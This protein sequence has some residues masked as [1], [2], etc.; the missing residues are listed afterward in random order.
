MKQDGAHGEKILEQLRN[1]VGA[2][3]KTTAEYESANPESKLPLDEKTK[4]YY[5]QTM[6]E[7]QTT[8]RVVVEHVGP[9]S[10]E[11][12]AYI[13]ESL[14]GLV[15]VE[16]YIN[17]MQG[18]TNPF[19]MRQNGPDTARLPGARAPFYV[20]L[21]NTIPVSGS[22][23][24]VDAGGKGQLLVSVCAFRPDPFICL[25]QH[26]CF[27]ATTS[28]KD[29]AGRVVDH[30]RDYPENGIA[31]LISDRDAMFDFVL[32]DIRHKYVIPTDC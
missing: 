15:R 20:I 28:L 17:P 11:F 22:P 9:R 8:V 32:A 5:E 16:P 25:L 3:R 14:L 19:L 26:V 12:A 30:V 2:L 13:S 6:K 27:T 24:A 29:L 31:A 7:K 4:A 18:Q 21:V 23:E 1:A 10:D